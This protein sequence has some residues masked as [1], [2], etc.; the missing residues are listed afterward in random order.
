LKRRR[1]RPKPQKARLEAVLKIRRTRHARKKQQ[2]ARLIENPLIISKY[3]FIYHFDIC[4]L[5][6]FWLSQYITTSLHA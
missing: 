6:T 3:W 5:P 4:I 1:K 2:A